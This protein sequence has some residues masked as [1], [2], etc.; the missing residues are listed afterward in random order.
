MQTEPKRNTTM[1]KIAKAYI[2]TIAAAGFFALALAGLR[3]SS[4]NLTRFAALLFLALLASGLKIRLPGFT[5]T[6]S[7]NFVFI[8]VGIAVL[9]FSETTVIGFA[10]A[11]AQS[12]WK[13]RQRPKPVQFLFNVACLAICSALAYAASHFVSGSLGSNSLV[14][15]M[16]LGGCFY[17]VLNTGLVSA[18]VALAEGRPLRQ[19]W[20][21]CYEWVF[22]YFLVGSAV[23]GLASGTSRSAGWT[24]S[25]LTL[26]LM[27]F[28]YLFYRMHV[29]R[30][31][32]ASIPDSAAE[33]E[34]ILAG[35]RER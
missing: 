13:T 17:L 21:Q 31:T 8:L 27:Y 4:D 20:Q 12:L 32:P 16:S 25:L 22:P 14:A 28:F 9:S 7:A 3:W 30:E 5:G 26:P 29:R 6:V 35:S 1:P 34:L 33:E 24:T 2:A 11:L 19:V 18:V 15:L 23:A 10:G